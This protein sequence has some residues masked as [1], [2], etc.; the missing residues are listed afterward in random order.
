[1]SDSLTVTH[2]GWKW[3]EAQGSAVEG[4]MELHSGHKTPC[5]V[6]PMD[7]TVSHASTIENKAKS[8]NRLALVS[9]MSPLYND[10]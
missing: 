2:S 1:M 7:G 3:A 10:L 6:P 8:M 4:E 9:T 5:K